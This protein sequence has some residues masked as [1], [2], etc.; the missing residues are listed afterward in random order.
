MWHVTHA[1]AGDPGRWLYVSY[2]PRPAG[3]TRRFAREV[4]PLFAAGRLRPVIDSRF[5]LDEVAAA[6]E[7]ME[8]NANVGKILLDVG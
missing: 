1:A 6:H 4:L 7:R 3:V 2:R 8:A 5:P